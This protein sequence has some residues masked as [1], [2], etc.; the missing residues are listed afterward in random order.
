M[1]CWRKVAA[2]VA[3]IVATIV[4]LLLLCAC[5]VG[6]NYKRPSLDVPGQY[7]GLPPDLSNQPAGEPFAQ[8]QC[9]CGFSGRS[10]PRP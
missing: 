8:L 10:A 4:P 7:R 6:P 1:I 2:G 5:K 3:T 9:V